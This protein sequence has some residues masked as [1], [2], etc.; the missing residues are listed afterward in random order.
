VALDFAA[1]NASWR[2]AIP[3]VAAFAAAGLLAAWEPRA[4]LGVVAAVACMLVLSRAAHPWITALLTFLVLQDPLQ[5]LAGGDTLLAQAI[6]RADEPIVLLA[7]AGAIASSPAVRR[8]LRFGLLPWTIGLAYL[9]VVASTIARGEFGLPQVIDAGMYSKPFLLFALGVAVA[10]TD[11]EVEL[12]APRHALGMTAVVAFAAV[13]LLFPALQEAYLGGFRDADTRLGFLSAQGFFVG[14]GV[15]SWFAAATFALA[16][17]GYLAWGRFTWLVAA[18]IGAAFT[19]LSWRRR[20]IVVVLAVLAL[21]VVL[22]AKRGRARAIA[23]TLAA[24]LLAATVLAPYLQGLW[25]RTIEEYG[26]ADS[27]ATARHALYFGS[28]AI[29]KD[30]FPLGLGFASFGSWASGRWYSEAYETYGLSRVW[31]LQPQQP[32]FITDTFWPMVLGQGGVVSLA[33]YAGFLALLLAAAWRR[34]RDAT[35]PADR[36]VAIAATLLLFGSVIESS[37]SHIYGSSLQAALA[38]VPAGIVWRREAERVAQSAT[39]GGEVRDARPAL[40]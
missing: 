39:I 4:A 30:R 36:F 33:G 24:A 35:R 7:G 23:V 2:S 28:T 17:A 12:D 5:L 34:A 27:D 40:R 19:L 8:S 3:W 11:D 15:Y 32:L 31:G 14:P 26:S 18:A 9:G 13:F 21:S 38:L 29:A 22:R 6:K 25:T 37:S 10:P 20:S 1:V 16:Y